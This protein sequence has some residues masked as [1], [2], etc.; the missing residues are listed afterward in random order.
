[1]LKLVMNETKKLNRQVGTWVMRV[2]LVLFILGAA[3]IAHATSSLENESGEAWKT[4]LIEQNKENEKQLQDDKFPESLKPILQK[5]IELYNY[6]IEHNLSASPIWEFVT[7]T[8][9]LI[10]LITVFSIIVAAGSV[11]KEFSWGTIKLLMI[12]P[13]SRSKML[14]S[15]Y[16]S[17]FQ[18]SLELMIILLVSSFL[19]GGLF[20]GFQQLDTNFLIYDEGKIQEVNPVIYILQTYGL[21]CISLLVMTTLAFMISTLFRSSSIAIGVSIA[22]VFTGGTIVT[23]FSKF[24]WVK[25]ILFANTDL[26]QYIHGTPL[27]EGMSLEFSLAVVAVYYLLFLLLTWIPF[28]K[29]DIAS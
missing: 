1:M 20:F 10:S 13:V 4:A 23:I 19:I 3:L 18:Y 17:T 16:L 12:R 7:I 14:L 5:E 21:N 24:E 29:R 11:S 27:Q 26:N 9:V 22:L 8:S 6:R 28:N 25:Y 2:I 15:K